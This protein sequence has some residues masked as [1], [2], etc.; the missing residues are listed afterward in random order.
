M[1]IKHLINHML[2]NKKGRAVYWQEG[3]KEFVGFECKNGK[4]IST[5]EVTNTKQLLKDLKINKPA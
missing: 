5:L 4:I 2:G 1:K 3:S